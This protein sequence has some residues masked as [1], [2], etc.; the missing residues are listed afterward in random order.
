MSPD[1]AI[2]LE[3][4]L[5]ADPTDYEARCKLLGYYSANRFTD[6]KGLTR[7]HQHV[8]WVI[9]NIPQE[10]IASTRYAHFD[11]SIDGYAIYESG[12]AIWLDNVSKN[13][14]SHALVTAA[15]LYI[16]AVDKNAAAELSKQGD[17]LIKEVDTTD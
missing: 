17:Q 8:L 15:A 14:L 2:E 7:F 3:A 6:P 4:V 11:P 10:K 5:A 9:A 1:K 16:A 12:K 13:P